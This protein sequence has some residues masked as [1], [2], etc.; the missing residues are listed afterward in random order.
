M[1]P[2]VYH[3]MFGYDV[4]RLPNAHLAELE[5]GVT[6]IEEARPRTGATIGYPGWG[7]IYHLLLSHLDR[8]RTE[9]LIETGT[10]EGCTTIILA[11]ALADAG[12]KGQVHT[13]ELEA[14]N[15]AKAK[16]NLESGGLADRVILHQ[17]SVHDTFGPALKEVGKVRFA[18]LDAS[19]LVRDVMFE[20]ETLFPY[21]TP[22]A[23]VLFD[24]TY[25]I[26][27][28]EEDQRV[29]GALRVILEKHGGNLINLENV[30]WF[31]PG[32]AIWQKTP[33]L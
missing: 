33:R 29:N 21:L 18:F 16:H 32:L 20:F 23:I 12:V 4:A 15:V 28:P 11:Q 1:N 5:R 30:S 24:N 3:R 7:F 2:P 6:S 13:F 8:N 27:E 22:D 14:T 9:N 10:N 31:T 25:K 19:H 17:G 26:A